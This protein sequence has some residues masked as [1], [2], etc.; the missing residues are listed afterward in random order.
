M[1]ENEKV[2]DFMVDVAWKG[3]ESIQ[4]SIDKI[5]NKATNMIT[6]SGILMSIVGAIFI[7]LFDKL[8]LFII[9][10]LVWDLVL[11]ISCI[12]YSFRTIYLE[13]Q[14]IPDT[15]KSFKSLDLTDILQAKGEYAYSIG[16]WQTRAQS[17][18]ND[19]SIFLKNSMGLFIVAIMFLVYIIIISVF[20]F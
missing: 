17:I 12:L 9:Y 7:D 5:E 15:I 13:K 2:F 4:D 6:F 19:K 20:S 18:F 3:I 14:E 11:F 8:H 16:K 10:G 1:T